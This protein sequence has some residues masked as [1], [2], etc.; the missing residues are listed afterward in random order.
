M[1]TL[2]NHQFA[3]AFF[4]EIHGLVEGGDGALRHFIGWRLRGDALQ[5]E[6]RRGHQGEE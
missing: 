6:A 4:F 5:P 1:G 3:A 2:G